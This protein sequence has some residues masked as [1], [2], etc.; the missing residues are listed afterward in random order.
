MLGADRAEDMLRGAQ[1]AALVPRYTEV[2]NSRSFFTEAMGKELVFIKQEGGIKPLKHLVGTRN[3][4]WTMKLTKFQLAKAFPALEHSSVS[5]ARA[6]QE[7][8]EFSGEF[9]VV[10]SVL[11]TTMSDH[12]CV[13]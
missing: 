8:F 4:A 1:A 7:G 13:V 3:G 9:L 12:F 11:G 10:G 5:C 2:P 6:R